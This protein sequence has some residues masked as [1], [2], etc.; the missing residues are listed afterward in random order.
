MGY[1]D[2]LRRVTDEE[3]NI[4][5]KKA[6]A[7]ATRPG[8]EIG[9]DNHPKTWKMTGHDKPNSSYQERLPIF[10]NRDDQHVNAIE[11]V[12]HLVSQ[13]NNPTILD[14][15]CGKEARALEELHLLYGTSIQLWGLDVKP[16]VPSNPREG[17]VLFQ[18]N[19]VELSEL[20][21]PNSVDVIVSTGALLYLH[22]E[23]PKSV[24]LGQMSS[25]LKIGGFGF[26]EGLNVKD[27]FIAHLNGITPYFP[28]FLYDQFGVVSG[29][30]QCSSFQR[31]R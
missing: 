22:H 19:I 6:I 23:Y 4:R 20:V 7:F 5:R 28:D 17:I 14:L 3:A 21:P 24:L 29:D 27:Y 31:I 25:R 13:G 10:S 16:I 1:K 12:E 2:K 15:G 8:I 26:V 11:L 30:S 9:Y 18:G